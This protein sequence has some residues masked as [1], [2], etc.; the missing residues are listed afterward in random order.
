MAI[1][2]LD[3]VAF[4]TFELLNTLTQLYLGGSNGWKSASHT[5]LKIITTR[6]LRII[7]TSASGTT[8]HKCYG[9]SLI[10]EKLS[11]G[12][13]YLSFE[14]L[15]ANALWRTLDGMSSGDIGTIS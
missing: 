2:I 11:G 6:Y 8:R 3:D 15:D 9:V 12:I 4:G 1:Q 10:N 13:A 7:V 14:I 5:I